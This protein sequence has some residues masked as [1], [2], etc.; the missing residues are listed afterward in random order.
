MEAIKTLTWYSLLVVN[1]VGVLLSTGCGT[2]EYIEGTVHGKVI[3]IKVR[4]FNQI[5]EFSLRD[6][7]GQTWTFAGESTLEM[8]APHLRKHMLTGEEV[9]V[10]YERRT[11]G[12]TALAITDFP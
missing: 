12:L 9:T 6:Q 8:T 11:E 7:E 4:S 5:E 2:Y 3:D 10:R 1:L